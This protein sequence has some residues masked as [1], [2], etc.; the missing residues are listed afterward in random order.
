MTTYKV[1][2]EEE[3][4]Q[5]VERIIQFP[6]TGQQILG[7]IH[8]AKV[9]IVSSLSRSSDLMLLFIL[10]RNPQMIKFLQ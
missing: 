5:S 2:N 6:L 4:R 9:S 8:D 3:A 1:Q 10:P 7:L